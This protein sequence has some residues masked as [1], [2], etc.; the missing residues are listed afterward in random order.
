MFVVRI[1]KLPRMSH[2]SV[3]PIVRL[4]T[5]AFVLTSLGTVLIVQR[6]SASPPALPPCAASGFRVVITD[7]GSH[8]GQALQSFELKNVGSYTCGMDGFPNLSFYTKTSLDTSL[9]IVHRAN[10]YATLAPKL[11]PVGPGE[12][13]SFGVSYRTTAS[14]R[15]QGL[16]NCDVE[17]ILLQLPLAPSSI[18]DFALRDEFNAC[19]AGQ[20]IAVTPVE[21]RSQPL[22]STT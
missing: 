16:F 5:S 4:F 19:R 22:L 11:I 6:A 1:H 2:R 21:A 8:R 14:D 12:V 13:V 17:S 7:L 20:V 3:L 18:G 10:V 9:R 15:D